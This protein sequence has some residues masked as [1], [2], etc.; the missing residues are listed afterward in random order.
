MAGRLEVKGAASPGGAR[1]TCGWLLGR[2]ACGAAGGPGRKK[3]WNAPQRR[4]L[5]P[6]GSQG[7]EPMKL[8]AA[9]TLAALLVSGSVALAQSSSGSA[10]GGA[11][12]SPGGSPSAAPSANPSASPTT[13][14]NPSAQSTPGQSGTVGRAPRTAP[15]P[16]AT[17]L[18][19][20][21]PAGR[22]TSCQT[23]PAAEADLAELPAVLRQRHI[24][25]ARDPVSPHVTRCPAATAGRFAG[26]R[27]G[28]RLRSAGR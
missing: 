24:G 7:S 5:N 18:R 27:H 26:R 9:V 6:C 2:D 23:N 22:P 16:E 8:T 15:P 1:T 10:G 19:T 13:Q 4:G 12:G 25:A 17:I 3:F 14:P 20:P 28:L 21:A 11:A